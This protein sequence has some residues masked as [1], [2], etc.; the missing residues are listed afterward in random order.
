MT[1]TV[2]GL[3][4]YGLH[5]TRSTSARGGGFRQDCMQGFQRILYLSEGGGASPPIATLPDAT[6]NVTGIVLEDHQG[7]KAADCCT[8]YQLPHS[9]RVANVDCSLMARRTTGHVD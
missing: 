9:I 6:T 8:N 7:T 1:S 2:P 5:C 3:Y 4:R